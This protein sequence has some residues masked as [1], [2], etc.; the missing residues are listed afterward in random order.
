MWLLVT[1]R[2]IHNGRY[3]LMT[4]RSFVAVRWRYTILSW[5][6]SLW[7]RATRCTRNDVTVFR[8]QTTT[9]RDVI[10]MSSLARYHARVRTSFTEQKSHIN[11]H[12]IP[13]NFISYSSTTWFIDCSLKYLNGHLCMRMLA[14]C[15]DL[16]IKHWSIYVVIYNRLSIVRWTIN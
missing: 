15:A 3:E 12:N 9:I 2:S 6:R 13:S 11:F 1:L 16:L 7:C 4:S 8:R 10:V 14:F 5:R